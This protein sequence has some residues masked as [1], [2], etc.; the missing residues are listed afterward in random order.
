VFLF[1]VLGCGVYLIHVERLTWIK[2]ST[3]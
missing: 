3:N 1:S 2:C